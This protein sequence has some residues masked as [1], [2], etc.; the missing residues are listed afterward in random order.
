MIFFALRPI[1]IPKKFLA[2]TLILSATIGGALLTSLS[3][4]HA[5]TWTIEQRQDQL[6]Q[7]IN[8]GQ[9]NKE[10]TFKEAKSLRKALA[11][12]A[13]DKK[14]M[15]GKSQNGKLTAEDKSALEE[16]LNKISQD[17]KKKELEKRVEV[18]K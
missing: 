16:S 14:E 9:K 7:D 13:R 12:V 17:L 6:M 18:A 4:V 8:S 2:V 5:K 1:M 15:L 10:L 11:G 3:A